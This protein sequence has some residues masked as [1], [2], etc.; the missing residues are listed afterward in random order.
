M[1]Q[2]FNLNKTTG[3]RWI[4]DAYQGYVVMLPVVTHTQQ[5]TFHKSARNKCGKGRRPL[6]REPDVF[7]RIRSVP[8][9]KRSGILGEKPIEGRFCIQDAVAEPFL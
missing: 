8:D 7:G 2:L 4:T 1:F 9:G 6:R 5:K 3:F